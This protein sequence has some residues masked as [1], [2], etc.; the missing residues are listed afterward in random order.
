METY[1]RICL[2]DYTIED[3]EGT[4][5]TI[6]RGKEYLTSPITK[7]NTLTIFS[8][9]WINGIPSNLFGGKLSSREKYKGKC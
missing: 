1:K 2:K 7:D 6:K 5:F 8:K 9:Y 3:S 4:K